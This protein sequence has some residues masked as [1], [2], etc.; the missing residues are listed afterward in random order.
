MPIGQFRGG[1]RGIQA[2]SHISFSRTI[3]PIGRIFRP[4]DYG[5]P[6]GTDSTI[7]MPLVQS[8]INSAVSAGGGTVRLER[9]YAY[10]HSGNQTTLGPYRN[11]DYGFWVNGSNIAIDGNGTGILKIVGLPTFTNSYIGFL[12]GNGGYTGI[13]PGWDAVEV[14]GTWTENVSIKNLSFDNSLLTDANLS[15]LT[16]GVIS[17]CLL[18]AFCRNCEIDGI[19][20]DRGWGI[21]GAIST[22]CSSILN[23]VRNCDIALSQ[24]VAYWFDGTENSTFDDLTCNSFL[25]TTNANGLTIAINTDYSHGSARNTVKNCRLAGVHTGIGVGGEDNIVENNT[26]TVISNNTTHVGV[27]VGALAN[28]KG[29]WAG[30]RSIIRNNN[31]VRDTSDGPRGFGVQLNGINA[32]AYDGLPLE[33]ADANV[34][35]NTFGSQ[36]GQALVLGP[37]ANRNTFQH[38]TI[39]C[40]TEVFDNSGGTAVGNV[41]GPNP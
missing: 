40:A 7:D 17:S 29:K 13:Y 20:I 32:N 16:G 22:H 41:I 4:E 3:V 14:T 34:Y 8:A 1:Y 18:L 37:Q 26:I 35:G 31:F 23:A 27:S 24:R 21:T 19:T 11:R 39:N 38:N 2:T 36:L 15:T 28:I 9:T 25:D 5:T 30:M 6:T 33:S 10:T 12:V